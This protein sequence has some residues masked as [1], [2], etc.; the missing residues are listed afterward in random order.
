MTEKTKDRLAIVN[1]LSEERYS[2]KVKADVRKAFSPEDELGIHRKALV[3]LFELVSLLHPDA[4]ANEDFKNLN[5]TVEEIKKKHE[6]L[7]N[8]KT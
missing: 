1:G 4:V 2:D 7:K 5:A 3:Q 6:E 8:E